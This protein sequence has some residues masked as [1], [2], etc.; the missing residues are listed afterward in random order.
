M[1]SNWF[2]HSS[3]GL[4]L[5]AFS[6]NGITHVPFHDLMASTNY[7]YYRRTPFKQL[8]M[9]AGKAKGSPP[10]TVGRIDRF[11]VGGL[12]RWDCNTIFTCRPSF[13]SLSLSLSLLSIPED[14]QF[15]L[16]IG[17]CTGKSVLKAYVSYSI[18]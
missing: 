7:L 2:R 9:D 3:L 15:T 8:G 4:P 5:A 11:V 17:S 1:R 16:T 10:R 13:V 6:S 12:M 14:D 18:I